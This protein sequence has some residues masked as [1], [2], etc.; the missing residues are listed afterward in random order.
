[1]RV[2][3]QSSAE[4]HGTNR[5]SLG[6]K[7][8]VPTRITWLASVMLLGF[9]PGIG[10]QAPAS[11]PATAVSS[12]T[13]PNGDPLG[14]ET[15]YGCVVGFL[16]HADRGDYHRAAEYLDART[17]S[18][19]AEEL[20]RQLQ[21]VLDFGLSGSLKGLARTPE[22]ELDDGLPADRERVGFVKAGS[23]TLEI[24][25]DRVQRDDKPPIWLF[26]PETLNGVPGA[27]KEIA[28][29]R[30]PSFFPLPFFQTRFLS[31]PLWRWLVIIVGIALSLA[32]A[33]LV[34]RALM[35]L[36]RCLVRRRTGVQDDRRVVA[37]RAPVRL[38]MLAVAIGAIASLSASLVAREF[39]THSAEVLAVVG[40]AWLVMKFSDIFSD[41]GS[42][43]LS[44]RRAPHK[45]A[46]LALANRFFKILVLFIAVLV[47]LR[48]FG[49]NV[50]AM[51]AGLG[52]GG[53]ALALAAQKTLESFLGGI[54]VT[55]RDVIRVGDFC[56]IADQTGTIEDIRLGSTRIRTLDRTVVSVSNAQVSQMNLENYSMRDKFRFR[57][58][59]G[60]PH[61]TLPLQLRSVL[62]ELEN[63]LQTDLTVEKETARV[64]FI[65]FGSSSIEIE[66][67]AYIKKKDYP[68]FLRA[69]EE[70]LLRMMDVLASKGTGMALPSQVTY[71]DHDKRGPS[72]RGEERLR[73]F[74]GAGQIAES[75]AVASLQ[76]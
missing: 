8:A 68:S 23:G 10:A 31:L 14:R 11:K 13:L 34:T 55:M 32:A 50:T 64:R 61:D 39:W 25:L 3:T 66:I 71:I 1:M 29:A 74:G 43:H 20:A 30:L 37:L 65:G 48:G 35:I 27:F 12:T 63:L 18:S 49:I 60:L 16:K 41:V 72:G 44:R 70:L 9:L 75:G 46:V 51:L 38:V 40:V 69:Q 2:P 76:K 56:R 33:S 59:F 15:P 17:T 58:V 53:L 22:G 7:L 26:S 28:S 52:V 4:I 47:L 62:T 19:R 6:R 73:T 21:V 45:V 36:L 57:H 42:Q 5:T 67:F 54:D 24:L